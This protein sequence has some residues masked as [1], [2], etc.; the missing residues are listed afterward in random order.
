MASCV[1]DVLIRMVGRHGLIIV[2]GLILPAV[3]LGLY[4]T[5]LWRSVAQYIVLDGSQAGLQNLLL[6]FCAGAMVSSILI[7]VGC[8]DEIIVIPLPR[9]NVCSTISGLGH[10]QRRQARLTCYFFKSFACLSEGI[11][12]EVRS[13]YCILHPRK[14]NLNFFLEGVSSIIF[15]CAGLQ[16]SGISTSTR[17]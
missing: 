4:Y 11:C 10:P 16:T 13:L 1:G 6:L 17:F 14:F 15:S 3:I 7:Q 8:V 9:T 12:S 5:A 2:S